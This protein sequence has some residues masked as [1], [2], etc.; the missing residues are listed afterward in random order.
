M[1]AQRKQAQRHIF[2]TDNEGE[3]ARQIP[4]AN[5]TT[6][7]LKT[8]TLSREMVTNEQLPV[9]PKAAFNLPRTASSGF[10]G[11]PPPGN[12]SSRSILPPSSCSTRGRVTL[13]E[14]ASSIS[15]SNGGL[16]LS[17]SLRQSG[18]VFEE[19]EARVKQL[20]HLSQ[21]ISPLS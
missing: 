5:K 7:M 9:P 1:V 17:E 11:F 12:G 18:K 10:P 6:R 13:R 16:T 21:V 19:Q 15:G 20:S 2:A 8:P 3:V 14:V 4:L